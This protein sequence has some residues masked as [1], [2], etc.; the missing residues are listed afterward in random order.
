MRWLPRAPISSAKSFTTTAANFGVRIPTL[1][2]ENLRAVIDAAHRH[3]KLAVVDIL[4][5][6]AAKDAIAA[7]ADGLVHLFADQPPDEEFTPLAAQH[8]VFVIAT[9]SVRRLRPAFRRAPGR[10]ASR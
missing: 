1:S 7:R 10:K 5:E 8:H 6:H 3:G 9:L 4:S 2:K